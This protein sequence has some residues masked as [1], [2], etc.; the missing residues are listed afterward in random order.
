VVEDPNEYTNHGRSKTAPIVY[1]IRMLKDPIVTKEEE[2][3]LRLTMEKEAENGG[4]IFLAFE[5]AAKKKKNAVSKKCSAAKKRNNIKPLSSTSSSKDLDIKLKHATP[6]SRNTDLTCL[7]AYL[8]S[9]SPTP[10]SPESSLAARYIHIFSSSSL[11]TNPFSILGSWVISIPARMGHNPT[12]DLAVE[13]AV[14]A[15]LKFVDPSWERVRT[16][17]QSKA[18]ALK[19]LYG[20]L[21]EEEESGKERGMV[22]WELVLATKLHFSAEVSKALFFLFF[23]QCIPPEFEDTSLFY[24]NLDIKDVVHVL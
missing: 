18:K 14:N 6:R 7:S 20:A 17:T 1:P 16:A 10:E 9:M 4:G 11:A 12:L 8:T 5:P 23:L 3:K 24:K 21:R 2:S 15:F 22:R 19:S 13:F